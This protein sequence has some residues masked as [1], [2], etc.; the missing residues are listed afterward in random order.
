MR[1]LMAVAAAFFIMVTACAAADD[2]VTQLKDF[3]LNYFKPVSG[4][5]TRVDG[6]QVTLSAPDKSGLKP[7]MRLRVLREGAPFYHPVTKENLGK[8]E[9]AVGKVEIRSVANGIATASLVE[10]EARE[11]DRVRISETK[12]RA[13]FVQDKS[14][15]W[16]LA[17]DYYRKLKASGRIELVDTNL[18]RDD[19]AAVLAEAKRLTAEVAIIITA[20]EQDK[21]TVMRER[22][23]WVSD[24]VRFIDTETK[25]DA[26]YT[27][28]LKFGDEFFRPKAGEAAM[29]FDLP[30]SSRFV[31]MGDLDG[32]GKKDI[33][34]S[35]G[36]DIRVYAA[37]AELK[38]LWEIKSPG[39]RDHIWMDTIDLNHNN[40]D[41]LVVTAM[42]DDEVISTVYELEGSAFSK[43][44]ETKHF[45]RRLGDG[46]IGQAYSP[47]AGYSGSVFA[48]KWDGG[49]RQG[50]PLNLSK[51]INIYDF[52]LIEGPEKE[53]L[54]F[55][56]DDTGYLNLYDSKGLR[57]WRSS[58]ETGGFISKF[59][60]PS[61]VSYVDAGEW[62]VKDRLVQRQR[63][64]L[65]IFRNP[66]TGVAKGLGFK[67]S[68]IR[69]YW[70]NGFAMEEAVLI[71]GVGG[72]ILDYAV[73][74][75]QVAVLAS[76]MMGLK[77][78]NIL[79]GENPL[80]AML[81]IYSL[82]GR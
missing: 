61:S 65:V 42:G 64:V 38:L 12:I 71:D 52:V 63:E 44:W 54:V 33:I 47:S 34:L 76:P 69:D 74:G 1:R 18:E 22:A 13:L 25:V 17:D 82:K 11:S 37:G 39:R 78:G 49:Y 46:L 75:D 14:I 66:V 48:V 3:T 5:I 67:N 20:R 59:K 15:D 68:F 32:D 24:G 27:K 30:S 43:L 56:Y 9:S 31:A 55:A 2:A 51:G 19:E 4:S 7:G 21:A 16:Y 50:E 23:Y 81:F 80:G 29:A 58:S 40:R 36:T 57:L 70:W 35:N 8:M 62:A 6:A 79:K 77:F 41:E 53:S 28:E 73:S 26:N 72:S 10:G 60:R 45:L